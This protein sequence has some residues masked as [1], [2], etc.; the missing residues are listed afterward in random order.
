MSG[1]LDGGQVNLRI[2]WAGSSIIT[3]RDFFKR[4]SCA[5]EATQQL[6]SVR[7]IFH[8]VRGLRMKESGTNKTPSQ[9]MR[10]TENNRHPAVRGHV[11]SRYDGEW[12]AQHDDI[13]SNIGSHLCEA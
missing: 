5:A 2:C 13:Q 4:T 10:T 6:Q 3:A 8:L 11:Q 9:N 12:E 7:T 1:F